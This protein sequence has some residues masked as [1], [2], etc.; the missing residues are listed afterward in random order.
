MQSVNLSGRWRLT[1]VGRGEK[2][3]SAEVP[4]I[5]PGCVH[6]DLLAAGAIADPYSRDNEKQLH[7]IG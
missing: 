4:A 7:W 5:V 1:Q 2:K 3:L 6:T